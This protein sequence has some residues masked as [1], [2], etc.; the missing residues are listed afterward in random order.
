MPVEMKKGEF[1]ANL[2]FTTKLLNSFTKCFIL[3]FVLICKI[4]ILLIVQ[5]NEKE[6][7][8]SVL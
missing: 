5:T 8:G 1:K 3:L 2:H 4:F 6:W 7:I